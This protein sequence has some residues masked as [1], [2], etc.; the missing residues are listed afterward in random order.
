M[1]DSS[2]NVRPISKHLKSFVQLV[3]EEP[4]NQTYLHSSFRRTMCKGR[5]PHKNQVSLAVSLHLIFIHLIHLLIAICKLRNIILHLC[6][7]KQHHRINLVKLNFKLGNP[8]P[9]SVKS[10][11]DILLSHN[12]QPHKF[13]QLQYPQKPRA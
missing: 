8:Y 4:R 13:Q 3:I 11:K 10:G 7:S 9:T 5:A 1:L 2:I 6:L 12:V